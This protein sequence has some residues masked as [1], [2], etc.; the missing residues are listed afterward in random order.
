[1]AVYA[2]RC[3]EHGDHEVHRPIGTAAD[4]EP[5][6]ECAVPASRVFTAPLLAMGSARA[7]AL[8]DRTEA[9]ATEP[10]VVSVPPPSR[11]SA[12]RPSNP[13]LAKLPRP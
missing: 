8:L 13:A 6:P 10:P 2:Y 9:S 1:M 7:R 4:R 5:C 3:A 11:R 12:P